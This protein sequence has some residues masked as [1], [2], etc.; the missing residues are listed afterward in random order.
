MTA[1]N[2]G[3]AREFFAAL[4]GG[5]LP[6]SLLTPD[7]AAWTTS[8]GAME[9]SRYQAGVKLLASVFSRGL[10]YTVDSLTAEADRVAAEVK[11]HGTL[12]DGADFRNT[13][14]FILRIR[15]GLI[16]SVAEHFNPI[17]VRE[18]I[19]PLMQAAMAAAQKR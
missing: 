19:V 2:H 3:V 16:A 6:D 11:A 8:S 7:M 14:V 18:K 10:T 17:V 13:Y 12:I 15:D 9:K 5:Q 4:S 1:V